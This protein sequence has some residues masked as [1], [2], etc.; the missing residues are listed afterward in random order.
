M[1][2]LNSRNFKDEIKKGITVVDF[3]APWCAP[4][5]M[6]VPAVE[7]LDAE[8]EDINFAKLNVDDAQDIA[9]EY[10]VMSIPTLII[11][12]DSDVKDTIIGVTT[13]ENIKAAIQ[14]VR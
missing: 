14:S 9:I 8:M 7:E 3:W 12:K 13:K 10:G 4:C 11:Y 6:I 2:T 5:R 1:K